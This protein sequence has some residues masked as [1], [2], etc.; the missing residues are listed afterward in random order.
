MTE[1]EPTPASTGAQPPEPGPDA[2]LDDIQHDI[3]ETRAQL[4]NTVE[5][6][7]AKMNLPER[8][9]ETARAAQPTLVLAA[10]A[11]GVTLVA[12]LW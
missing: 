5:A 4:G 6:L 10:S 7:S 2:D 9:K 12:L 11:A 3:E 8:A 1:A